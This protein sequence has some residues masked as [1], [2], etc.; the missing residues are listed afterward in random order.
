ME[1]TDA[2]ST[3]VQE[4]DDAH[5]TLIQWVNKLT[6]STAAG[7]GK[8]DVMH[9]LNFLGTYARRHFAAEEECMHRLKCPMA[10]ANQL[11]HGEFVEYFT[12]IRSEIDLHGASTEKAEELQRALSHWLETHIL[13][14]DVSLRACVK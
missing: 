8:E 11:A 12:K 2:M 10:A 14:V 1:W 13:R 9:V 6:A 3:G 4:V 7:K 5:R